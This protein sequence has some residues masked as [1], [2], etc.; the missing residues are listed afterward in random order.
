MDFWDKLGAIVL[1]MDGVVF[2]GPSLR[3]GVNELVKRCAERLVE[4]HILTNTSAISSQQISE[5]L[6]R[7]GLQIEARRITTASELAAQYV[8]SQCEADAV[9]TIGGGTGLKQALEARLIRQFALEELSVQDI[10]QLR[11]QAGAPPLPLIIAWTSHY[12]YE[13]AARALRLEKRISCIYSTGDDQSFVTESGNVPGIRW[14]TGSISALLD[15]EPI[16]LGKPN[17]YALEHVLQKLGTT[18]PNTAVIGDSLSDIQVGSEAGCR[19]VLV[20]GGATPFS[21]LNELHG[22]P[23]PGLVI[24][25]LT[26]LL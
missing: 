10:N 23:V 14:V 19:T 1:D 24:D 15:K 26:D 5:N 11:N 16:N 22:S 3:R 7:M 20:L 2:I 12:D 21:A 6:A 4:L 25:E 18:P 13:L 9:F 8:W 17:P